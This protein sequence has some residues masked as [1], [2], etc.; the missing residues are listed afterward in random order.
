MASTSSSSSSSGSYFQELMR[1]RQRSQEPLVYE[2]VSM[3][4]KMGNAL[5]IAYGGFNSGL[6]IQ[7]AF[8]SLAPAGKADWAIYS[9]NGACSQFG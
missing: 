6:A 3:P 1:L 7:A 8:H 5:P 4:V 9:A 2:S